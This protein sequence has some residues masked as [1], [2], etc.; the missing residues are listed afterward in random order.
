M[1]LCTTYHHPLQRLSVPQYYRF[2]DIIWTI[3]GSMSVSGG[4]T[5]MLG[6]LGPPPKY[7]LTGGPLDHGWTL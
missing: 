3:G 1:L 4:A 6:F 7:L 5:V 2:P